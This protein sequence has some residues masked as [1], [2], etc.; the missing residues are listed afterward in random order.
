MESGIPNFALFGELLTE[1]DPEF[2]HIETISARSRL[3]DWQITP[4]SHLEL[5]QLVFVGSGA[6]RVHLDGRIEDV[7]GPSAVILPSGV[8]HAFSFEPETTGHV[9]TVAEILVAQSDRRQSRDLLETV[10]R[11]PRVYNFAG[12]PGRSELLESMLGH[13]HSE[14][15]WQHPGR[16]S[17]FRWYLR[18]V[19]M[20]LRRQLDVQSL[21]SISRGRRLGNFARFRTLLENHYREHWTVRD[22]AR[23]LAVSP[24]KLNRMC[25]QFAGRSALEVIH[26]RIVLEAQRLLLYTDAA[27][28]TIAEELGFKDPGYFCRFFLRRTSRT[29]MSF[30]RRE[31]KPGIREDA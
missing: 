13:M 24:S 27:V 2:V 11:Q 12:H 4:H 10:I 21:G 22:Y 6:A 5:F 29:P 7:R 19:L 23:V 18:I 20:T 3:Y 1:Q 25:R 14:L 9:V 30:R 8:V 28:T 15:Q 31:E 17:M 26:D 16:T